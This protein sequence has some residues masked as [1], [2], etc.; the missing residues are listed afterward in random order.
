MGVVLFVGFLWKWAPGASDVT[1]D[2]AGVTF[3]Y[4][5]GRVRRVLWSGQGLP[6]T[7]QRTEGVDDEISRGSPV[8]ATSGRLWLLDFLSS[9]TYHQL[10][11][12]AKAH[13]VSVTESAGL[14][15]GWIRV[16]L[17]VRAA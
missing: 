11:V 7:I 15:A 1:I 6:L 9:E 3:R 4:A 14:R 8:Q 5:G 10:I 13:G 16:T 2:D 17:S 12:T